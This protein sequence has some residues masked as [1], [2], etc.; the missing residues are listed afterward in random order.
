MPTMSGCPFCGIVAGAVPAEIV[1]ASDQVVAFRDLNP[2]APTH[3]LLVPRDHVESMDGLGREHAGLLADL[4]VTAAHVARAERVHESGWR[5]VSNMGP[6][7]GQSVFHLHFHLLGGRVMGWP[8][9]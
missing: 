7:A 4:F 2:K 8:P 3:V 9:G 1:H 5:L 6:D